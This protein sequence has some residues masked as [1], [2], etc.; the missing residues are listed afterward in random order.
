MNNKLDTYG[1]VVI[2]T[3]TDVLTVGD[4][5]DW[6][7]TVQ[8]IGA[9]R[10][11]ILTDGHLVYEFQT[12]VVDLISCGETIGETAYDLWLATHNHKED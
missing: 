4:V 11:T 3:P 7:D 9:T 12:E 2:S 8:K 6:L 5:M 10:E 1:N